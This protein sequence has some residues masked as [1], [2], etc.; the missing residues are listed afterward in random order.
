MVS[1]ASYQR[2]IDDLSSPDVSI[3]HKAKVRLLA[4]GSGVI[5]PLMAAMRSEVEP[6]SWRAA[7]VLAVL[8]DE[9][10]LDLMRRGLESTNPMLGLAA[11][12]FMQQRGASTIDLLCRALP[13]CLPIV[14][15]RV[16]ALLEQL[17]AQQAVE[18]LLTLL[19][20]AESGTLRYTIIQCLGVLGDPQAIR[21]IST[22]RDDPD[23]HVRQR[24]TVALERL[25]AY[26]PAL[27]SVAS[28][29]SALRIT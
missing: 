29:K 6:K 14:Q 8:G 4:Q 24:V 16:I 5:E 21:L 2:W 27:A 11:V 10:C 28:A 26:T 1:L 25:G 23:H 12:Q 20:K 3:R 18:P 9:R 22:F 7:E 15:V 17:H 19:H 13:A